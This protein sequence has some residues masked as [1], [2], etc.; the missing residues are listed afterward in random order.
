MANDPA[1]SGSNGDAGFSQSIANLSRRLSEQSARLAGADPR[2]EA[3]A[4]RAAL[5]AYDRAQSRRLIA[6]LTA[7]VAVVAAADIA[8][9]V[10]LLGAGSEPPPKA[11]SADGA[12]PSPVG[13]ADTPAPA[14]DS[15]GVRAAA[16]AASSPA[17]AAS[18]PSS[19]AVASGVATAP[20]ASARRA[21]PVSAV[22]PAST[23]PASESFAVTEAVVAAATPTALEAAA[24]PASPGPPPGQTGLPRRAVFEVQARLRSLGFNPGRI[25]GSVGPMTV[26]AVMHY[27]QNRGQVQTGQVDHRLLD[28]LRRD[29]ASAVARRGTA[30]TND[31]FAPL[32]TASNRF[33]QWLQSLGR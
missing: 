13:L 17:P 25:D 2:A 12:A 10:Y 33:S 15:S 27:Q 18:A 30:P 3:E 14:A 31:P 21:A 1:G 9:L 16:T 19:A 4:R 8:F 11:A 20:A 24:R 22:L 5:Q 32:R 7:A 28:E 26:G 23:L 6:A 29:P